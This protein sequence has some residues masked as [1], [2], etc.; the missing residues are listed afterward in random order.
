MARASQPVEVTNFVAGLVTDASPLTFPDNASL[1]EENFV[2][3][4]DGSRDRRLG[5]D[6]ESGAVIRDTSE[7]NLL[8]ADIGRSAYKWENAGGNADKSL[9]VVQFGS[10]IDIL[11]LDV[12]P[13][14]S[15]LVSSFSYATEYSTIFSY[16]EVDGRL[17]VANGLQT[18]P[19]LTYNGTTVTQETFR[20][21]VRD[22][23]GVED[24]F[25]GDDLMSG[26]NTQTRPDTQTDEHI[27]NLRNQGWGIP[28]KRANTETILDP[29]QA[30]TL[31]DSG[32]FPSNAD[33]VAYAMYADPNDTDDRV[34]NR[35]FPAEVKNNP[36]GSTRAALGHYII[37]LFNRGQSRLDEEQKSQDRYSQLIYPLTTL[38]TDQSLGGVGVVAEFAGRAFY[39]GFSGE[40]TGGDERSP[41]LSSY[42]CFSKLAET[43]ADLARCYQ[44]A[45]PTSVDANELVDTD[46]GFIRID[47]AFGIQGLVNIGSSLVILA[48]N[49][50]WIL[51][52]GSDYGFT[53]VAYK[54]SRIS[55]HGCR[56]K[57]SI[58]LVDNT[59]MYWGSDGIYHV[60]SNDFGDTVVQ[61]LTQNRIQK[62][63]EQIGEQS[64]FLCSGYYDTY[65]RKVRWVYDTSLN[66]TGEVKELV[67]DINLGSFYKNRIKQIDGASNK[68][69][70]VVA[71]NAYVQN[72]NAEDVVADITQP[73]A[74]TQVQADGDDVIV[75]AASIDNITRELIYITPTSWSTTVQY[76]ISTYNDTDFV[77]WRTADGTGVDA[78][79]YLLTGYMSAGDFW[80]KKQLPY[81]QMVFERTETGF[82]EVG[83]DFELLNQSSCLVQ[84]QW[85]WTNDIRGG[86]W[87][88][89][90]EYYRLNRL[91]LAELV[92]EEYNDGFPVVVTKDKLRG[93]G[94]VVSLLFTTSPGKDC[95]IQGWTMLMAV[96]NAPRR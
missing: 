13:I 29:I 38:P 96:E 50:I 75:T 30:Y 70:L 92:S 5:M 54:V 67:L 52:G 44:E 17:V 43:S 34:G 56:A 63:Y 42:L 74:L 31:E 89:P 88:T 93:S 53:A 81:L 73:F 2:L 4:Q 77:D 49:G 28:R 3:N 9:L 55:D 62:F 76:T 18:I 45:D 83:D 46:G 61:P 60:T 47:G 82:V 22:L 35:F 94:K 39:A 69:V 36:V 6:Y 8:T 48:Q 87:S 12:Q 16:A 10:R 19:I 40:I 58:V 26:S 64:I 91:Y 85:Q 68:P 66:D 11:D 57:N 33:S 14:S 71:G 79:A 65:E 24:L 80:R 27:Y 72:L 23:F 90:R 37:D 78:N 84:A 1:D 41:R 20:I 21:S 25:E 32:N 86:R 15:G 95:R 7:G 59:V 51:E